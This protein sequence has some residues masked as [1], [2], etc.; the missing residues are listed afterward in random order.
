[1]TYYSLE[2]VRYMP[3]D[4]DV[5]VTTDTKE[6][7]AE[8]YRAFQ[9]LPCN[10]LEVR[11]VPNRGR[12]LGPLLT[13]VRDV[14]SKYD[15]ICKV[16]DKKALNVR[17]ATLGQSFSYQCFECL[18]HSKE[19]VQNVINTF[20]E[21]PRVGMLMPPP[22]HYGDYYPIVGR[23][24]TINEK[25]TAGLAKKMGLQVDITPDKPP[26]APLGS[27]FWFRA[28]ALE[29]LFAIEWKPED[30]PEEPLKE[31][32]TILHGIERLFPFVVQDAG[33][34]PAWVMPDTYASVFVNNLYF[35][36]RSLNTYLFH[37]EFCRF[38]D[39]LDRAGRGKEE[40]EPEQKSSRVVMFFKFI[41]PPFIYRAIRY[42]GHL[43]M[44]QPTDS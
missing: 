8:I 44:H 7:Q 5:Y 1:M 12:D 28:K 25:V 13:G 26:I 37:G 21:N 41:L 17:P 34:Y 29:K 2:Y 24:W 39:L 6:K 18:L 35:Y 32:G 16:H 42:C 36:L 27:F 15:Y 19:Y 3:E 31:D 40:G 20:D 10:H 11:L 30:F 9:Q 38:S 23:E 43:A 22:P 14:I 33:Y 4:I